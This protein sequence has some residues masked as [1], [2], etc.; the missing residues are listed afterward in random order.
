MMFIKLLDVVNVEK[1]FI[2]KKLQSVVMLINFI[3]NLV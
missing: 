1:S 3:I 2:K